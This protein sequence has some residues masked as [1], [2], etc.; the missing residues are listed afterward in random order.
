[1]LYKQAVLWGISNKDT[2]DP[3]YRPRGIEVKNAE[4]DENPWEDAV[5]G[6]DAKTAWSGIYYD[7]KPN[8]T[9]Q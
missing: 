5:L 9:Y 3:L 1:M 4:D 2:K 7:P 8:I 6:M